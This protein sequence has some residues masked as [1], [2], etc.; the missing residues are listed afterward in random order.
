V[1]NFFIFQGNTKLGVLKTIFWSYIY[2]FVINIVH[3]KLYVNLEHEHTMYLFNSEPHKH[4]LFGTNLNIRSMSSLLVFFKER[5][6]PH[7]LCIL[8]K[9]YLKGCKHQGQINMLTKRKKNNLAPTSLFKLYHE[10]TC[11]SNLPTKQHI[12]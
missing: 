10:L 6:K 7:G 3:E 11:G 8:T 1:W 12:T 2:F 4:M 9:L 5:S